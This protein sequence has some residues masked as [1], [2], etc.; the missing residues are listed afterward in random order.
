[1]AETISIV[2]EKLAFDQYHQT[3]VYTQTNGEKQFATAVAGK[4]PAGLP[5]TLAA[6]SSSPVSAMSGSSSSFGE[7]KTYSGKVSALSQ[8]EQEHWLGSSQSPYPKKIVASGPSLSEQWRKIQLTYIKTDIAQLTYSPLTQNS[9][10]TASTALISAGI[11]P[12]TKDYS[13]PA[14]GRSLKL[15]SA[16]GGGGPLQVI[17]AKSQIACTGCPIPHPLIVT[18]HSTVVNSQVLRATIADCNPITNIVPFGPCAFTPAPP[19]PSGG[20]CIPKPL[21]MWS[22]GS[23]TT[24]VSKFPALR[25]TDVLQ[26]AMGGTIMV[27][28]PGQSQYFVQ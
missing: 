8:R 9:N 16:A 13:S 5:S 6:L 2:Y 4:T 1:M 14:A 26:C 17:A 20:P 10:S 3:L 18:S 24:I 7:L 23:S 21:G 11:T 12:S 25:Q 22:P 27:I 19:S 15:P 28:D